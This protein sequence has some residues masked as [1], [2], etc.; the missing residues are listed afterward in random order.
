[1]FD[2]TTIADGAAAERVNLEF[3]KLIENIADPNTDAKKVR[4]LQINISFTAD[5]ARD[6][7]SVSVQAK[8]TLAPAKSVETKI[9]LDRDMRGQVVAAELRQMALDLDGD[10]STGTTNKVVDIG[11]NAK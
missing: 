2:L 10:A 3:Q 7:A 5:E 1:M 9:M 8:S 6:I 11:R 4:K